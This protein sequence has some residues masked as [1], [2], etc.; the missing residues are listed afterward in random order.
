MSGFFTKAVLLLAALGATALAADATA[1]AASDRRAEIDAAMRR[2]PDLEAGE[3]RYAASCSACHGAQG[4]GQA[5]GWV[6]RIA[7]QRHAVLVNLLVDYR[8]GRRWDDRMQATAT[9][10]ALP[11]AQSIADVAAYASRLPGAMQG[12]GTGTAVQLGAQL[13]AAHCRTCHGAR[14]EGSESPPVPRLAGQ[15]FVY[16]VR[17]QHDLLEGRRPDENRD[18][19][20]LLDEFDV[21]QIQALADYLSRL[22]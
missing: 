17:Q 4:E 6:P 12:Q 21:T 19:M 9:G 15:N 11:D 22:Q 20:R 3:R 18:H 10:H 2:Q 16:L 13:Y 8:I 5:T 7:G 14:A 1:E